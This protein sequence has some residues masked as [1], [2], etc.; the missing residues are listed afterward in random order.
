MRSLAQRRNLDHKKT[1]DERSQFEM[2]CYG[3]IRSASNEEVYLTE[4]QVVIDIWNCLK[5]RYPGI[6]SQLLE[7]RVEERI[8]QVDKDFIIIKY[9]S[10]NEVV[11]C[12]S[13]LEMKKLAQGEEIW[14]A[15]SQYT[16]VHFFIFFKHSVQSSILIRTR[17][18]SYFS[19]EMFVLYKHLKMRKF[20]P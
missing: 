11:K 6:I 12:K 15:A 14:R 1:R 10:Y 8:G 13:Y 4:F 3:R 7:G 2:C 18:P 5:R 17:M 16:E 9:D 20:P 19:F